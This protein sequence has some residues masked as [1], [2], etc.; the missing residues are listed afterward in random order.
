MDD[1][2]EDGEDIDTFLGGWPTVD[3]FAS[4]TVWAINGIRFIMNK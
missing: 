2:A 1:V 4:P 3:W